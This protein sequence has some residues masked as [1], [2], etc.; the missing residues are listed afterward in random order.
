MEEEIIEHLF[1]TE[2][3]N[4]LFLTGFSKNE[5]GDLT[6]IGRFALDKN[7]FEGT[8]KKTYIT[9]SPSEL[10]KLEASNNSNSFYI[11]RIYRHSNQDITIVGERF[12]NYY[13]TSHRR[14]ASLATND[15]MII[16]LDTIGQTKWVQKVVKTDFE[17]F[18]INEENPAIINQY[19][20][21]G[22]AIPI[23]QKNRLTFLYLNEKATWLT[24]IE[25]ETG[26]ATM[27]KIATN[28]ELNKAKLFCQEV[29]L[30]DNNKLVTIACKKT[31]GYYKYKL[32]EFSLD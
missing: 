21:F 4:Q 13:S 2:Y 18:P 10:T 15:M 22:G 7:N 24:K 11:K 20:S 25:L 5:K 27:K 31:G 12:W 29:Q 9:L 14:Y 19:F 8:I 6:G 32:I 23:F 16:Q 28:K 26:K 3:K 30:L 1:F 17:A